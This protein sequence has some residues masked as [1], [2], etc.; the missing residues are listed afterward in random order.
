MSFHHKV[1]AIDKGKL[2]RNIVFLKNIPYHIFH[3]FDTQS[4]LILFVY[5]TNLAAKMVILIKVYF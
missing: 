5:T 4:I 2:V 3:I 1:D